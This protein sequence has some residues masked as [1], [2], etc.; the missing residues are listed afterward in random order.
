MQFDEQNKQ[1][2]CIIMGDHTILYQTNERPANFSK[3]CMIV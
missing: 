1:T 3:F 2:T